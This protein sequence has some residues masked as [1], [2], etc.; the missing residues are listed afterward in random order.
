MMTRTLLACLAVS[1]VVGLG[2]VRAAD[3]AKEAAIKKDRTALQGTWQAISY[4]LD[5]QKASAED[6]K[7]IKLVIDA[8]GKSSAQRD[9]KTFIAS[10]I[11]LDPTKTPKAIDMTYTEG[12]IQ[13][14][15]ALGIYKIEGDLLTICRVAP[16]MDRPAEFSSKPGSGYTLMT[17][18]REKTEV[19]REDANKLQGT[20]AC[21]SGENAGKPIP[22]GTVKKLRLV[23]TQDKYATHRGDELL[24]ESTYKLDATKSPWQ[25]DIIG[26]EGENKGKA[27]QGICRLEGDT[28]TLC[29]TMPSKD[30]P[31]QFESKAGSEATLTVWKRTKP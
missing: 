18:K 24:F 3:D 5:G 30:R 7:K 9:G 31:K 6:M 20:W 13:G 14:K 29:Y 25:I 12:E 8:E 27:A 4:A 22:E 1:S 11:K 17:Y 10:T 21:V 23:L 15:P 19:D 28:L 2:L 16:G 26:T